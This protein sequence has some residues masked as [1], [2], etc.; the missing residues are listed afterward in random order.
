MLVHWTPGSLEP[1]FRKKKKKNLLPLTSL[2][3]LTP[4]H[5]CN[6][7]KTPLLLGSF[8]W[9]SPWPQYT[10]SHLKATQGMLDLPIVHP[11][12]SGNLS[13]TTYVIII[14]CCNYVTLHP[15]NLWFLWSQGKCFPLHRMLNNSYLWQI[16][17]N[18]VRINI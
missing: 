13:I 1:S 6:S 7:V 2:F 9:L 18:V 10:S 4:N 8:L 11:K 17:V 12:I 15:M 16:M 3:L 14:F 5:L